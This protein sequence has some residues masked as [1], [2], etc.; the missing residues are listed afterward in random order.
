MR[1]YL[2][3]IVLDAKFYNKFIIILTKSR[4]VADIRNSLYLKFILLE[5]KLV[6]SLI[7][8]LFIQIFWY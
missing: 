1:L 4:P 5:I 8:S 2:N 3:P 7:V 6:C